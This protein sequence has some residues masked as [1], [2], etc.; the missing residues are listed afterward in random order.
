MNESYALRDNFSTLIELP[1]AD[2]KKGMFKANF[3]TAVRACIL[4]NLRDYAG[5]VLCK[6]RCWEEKP[7]EDCKVVDRRRM[8]C[9]AADSGESVR[10]R[11]IM[12]TIFV[13]TYSLSGYTLSG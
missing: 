6:R 7:M 13:D 4:G 11:N 9:A 12:L 10:T 1:L 5:S 3:T 8:L 2:N